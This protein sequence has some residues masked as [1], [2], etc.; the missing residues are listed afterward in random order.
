MN[1]TEPAVRLLQHLWKQIQE[2]KDKTL[3]KEFDQFHISGEAAAD[4]VVNHK[5]KM[6]S[7]RSKA[8]AWAEY[9][10][11]CQVYFGITSAG[12]GGCC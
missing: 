11:A 7:F 5:E 9:L 6:L 12:A 3:N 2:V 4:C 10:L 8:G 1:L